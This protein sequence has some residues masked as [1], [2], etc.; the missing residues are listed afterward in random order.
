MSQLLSAIVYCHSK[1]VFH[2]YIKPDN[3]IIVDSDTNNSKENFKV[4]LLD[5]GIS[6]IFDQHAKLVK[7][8]NTIYFTAPEVFS[9]KFNE[10][11]DV[12]SCGVLLYILL[13]GY[14]PNTKKIDNYEEFIKS[15]FEGD[16]WKMISKEAKNLIEKMLIFQPSNRP[17]I[18]EAFSHRWVQYKKKNPE[19]QKIAEIVISNL[20]G[21]QVK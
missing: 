7:Y 15:I 4:K 6:N 19:N 2:R 9:Q 5:I 12:W 10:K 17:T 18:R 20:Q 16:I 13:C 3:I 8:E 21:K 14:S 11:C 1:K